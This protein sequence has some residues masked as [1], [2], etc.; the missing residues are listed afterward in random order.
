MKGVGLVLLVLG[1]LFAF[2]LWRKFAKP[3]AI[4]HDST[5]LF[6]GGIGG[7]KTLN[8]VKVSIKAYRRAVRSW[9]L[10]CRIV[11]FRKFI[12]RYKNRGLTYREKPMFKAN[13]PVRLGRRGRDVVWSSVLTRED[14]TFK[15]RIPEGS[16]V[17][18]DELPQFINQYQWD[19]KDVQGV[20]NE[21][22]TY[23]RHYVNGLFVANAQSVDETVA[24]FRRKMNAYYYVFDFQPF[25]FFFYRCHILKCRIGDASVSL[26]NDYIDENAKW[27]YGC[28]F[29]RLYDSR[30]YRHRYD[31]VK[32]VNMRMF[33]DYT[34]N[35]VL[36]FSRSYVSVL[37]DKPL[38]VVNKGVRK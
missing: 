28:L 4:T 32:L 6:T 37:D 30:C 22:I 21:W 15:T 35:E 19:D 7:G 26:T 25:L 5:C 27:H 16:V 13:I 2:F 31:K 11:D 8:S 34:T 9:W 33:N 18:I 29:P 17:F 38:P 20:L 10:D 1:I 3:T 24:Q 23:F 14:L 36:R 12:N